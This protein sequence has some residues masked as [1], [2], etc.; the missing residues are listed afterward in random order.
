MDNSTEKKVVPK[1]KK[2]GLIVLIVGISICLAMF[3]VGLV[4]A[5]GENELGNFVLFVTGV[6]DLIVAFIIIRIG[7]RIGRYTCPECGS[8]RKHHRHYLETT[9]RITGNSE[10]RK[11]IYTHH[12]E[13]TY[14]C[15]MCGEEST[16]SVKKRG[17]EVVHNFKTGSINDK[18]I[19]P[20][21][22]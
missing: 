13:D 12:Y 7:V 21:E 15:P 5:L 4:L 9:E 11:Y 19:D 2:A 16:V 22:F 1:K 10:A 14:T 8:K 3:L 18:R 17:G 6:L 20:M